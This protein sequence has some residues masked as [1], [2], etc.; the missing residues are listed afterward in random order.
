MLTI[1]F[2]FLIKLLIQLSERILFMKTKFTSLLIEFLLINNLLPAQTIN[3][4]TPGN[5]NN[6]GGNPSRS[7]LSI[8]S[9]PQ[10][11]SIKWQGTSSGLFGMP[12]YIE[13]SKLVTMRFLALTN[14]PAVCHNIITGQLIWSKDVTG[15][16]GRSL[17]LGIRDGKVYVMRLTESLRDT[18][19]ALDANDGSVIWRANVTTDAYIT[20]SL[21]FASNGDLFVEGYFKFYKIDHLTG[22]KIW[23]TNVV[24]L[25]MGMSEMSVY[26][27][28]GYIWE[29]I[30]GSSNVTAIDINTG[31]RKYSRIITDTHPGGAINQCALI[32]GED[33]TIFA[34]KQEDNVTALSD[35]GSALNV[36]WQT[37]ITGNAPFSLMCTGPDGSVYAPSNGRIIRLNPLNGQR[38]DSSEVICANPDLFQLRVSAASNN[39]IYATNGENSVYAFTPELQQ[40]WTDFIPNVNTSGVAIG[41][42]GLAAVSGGG[43]TLKVYGSGTVGI[44]TSTEIPETF[45]LNQNYPNPFNPQTT[46]EF[47]I[48]ETALTELSVYNMT[49]QKIQTLLNSTLEK[50]K[51]KLSWKPDGLAS[52]VYLY[53]LQSGNYSL[54][55]KL[56]LIR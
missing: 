10:N 50:G 2:A 48:P 44:A 34:Q 3:S 35:V 37:E 30:G 8:L 52:G 1:S 17:P 23:E 20:T 18:L 47:E 26:N 24:P 11:D 41:A 49:G 12:V 7:G 33:G 43:T 14:A 9:G 28:T 22:I 29:N 51:H 39:V 46:I 6:G 16:T 19:F 32:I 55:K 56:N 4:S 38:R 40:L 21:T 25:V 5:W 54:T 42:N 31:A 15:L 36:L 27:N 13:G 53:R 45:I